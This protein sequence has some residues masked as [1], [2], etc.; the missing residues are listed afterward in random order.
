VKA[1]SLSSTGSLLDSGKA[2]PGYLF[3]SDDGRYTFKLST[4]G[5][6][7]GTYTLNYT[8]GNDPTVY[9]Y[10]FTIS[11]RT[12]EDSDKGNDKDKEGGK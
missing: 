2:N 12:S 5:L 11:S 4:K 7:A 9:H 10:A 3:R 8:I 6:S 1:V